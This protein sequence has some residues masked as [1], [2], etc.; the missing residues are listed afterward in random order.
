MKKI[1]EK[2]KQVFK[3]TTKVQEPNKES[4]SGRS[5]NGISLVDDDMEVEEEPVN[6][7]KS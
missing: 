7:E 6:E 4:Q 1:A 3:I 5:G 2:P